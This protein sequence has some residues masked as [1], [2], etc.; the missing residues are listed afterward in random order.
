MGAVWS[1]YIATLVP[2]TIF[3]FISRSFMLKNIRKLE[4]ITKEK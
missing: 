3:F 1:S 4:E 2:L